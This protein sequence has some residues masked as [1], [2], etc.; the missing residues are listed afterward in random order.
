VGSVRP[1]AAAVAEGRLD[2][3]K[4]KGAVAESVR[5]APVVSGRNARPAMAFQRPEGERKARRMSRDCSSSR[6]G[7]APV[8]EQRRGQV[9]PA[10]A[11]RA[12]GVVGHCP[13]SSGQCAGRWPCRGFTQRL[14]TPQMRHW[15]RTA[16]AGRLCAWCASPGVGCRR[17]R[18]RRLI[19]DEMNWSSPCSDRRG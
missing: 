9:L 19:G 4:H 14:S 10:P 17:D 11:P 12:F 8:I 16:C 5:P 2:L 3:R 13:G 6:H 15:K 18:N 1:P 7:I